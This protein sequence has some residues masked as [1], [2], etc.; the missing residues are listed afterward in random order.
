MKAKMQ[1][2]MTTNNPPLVR[3]DPSTIKQGYGYAR[4]AQGKQ[5]AAPLAGS[6]YTGLYYVALVNVASVPVGATKTIVGNYSLD[7]PIG[8]TLIRLFP[9]AYMKGP[10]EPTW[11][12]QCASDLA[13]C[14]SQRCNHWDSGTTLRQSMCT[15]ITDP[16]PG[17]AQNLLL[18]VSNFVT[19]SAFSGDL[20][21]ELFS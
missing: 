20:T 13:S 7:V 17:P 19:A 5:L 2:L 10:N 14:N 11:W 18:Q 9:S 3:I 1:A 6:T 16:A 8:T 4:D 21:V 12:V 15:V